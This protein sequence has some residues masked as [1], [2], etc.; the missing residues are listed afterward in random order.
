MKLSKFYQ[1]YTELPPEQRFAPFSPN[2]PQ[3]SLFIIYKQLEGV[4]AQLRYFEMRQGELLQQA[5]EGFKK[6]N[7]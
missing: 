7:V 3:T 2:H 4:R 1:Q 5:E 6:I